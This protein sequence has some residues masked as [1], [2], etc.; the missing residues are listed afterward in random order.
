M[1]TKDGVRLIEY[2]ARFGDPEAMNVLAVLNSDFAAIC[3]AMISGKLTRDLVQFA[4][5]ATVCKYAVPEGY[6]DH[7]V[8][9]TEINI[10]DV[11]NT[12]STL[13]CRSGYARE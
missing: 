12:R 10:S 13:S 9:N 6:P 1:A 2:N 4:N 11:K 5:L 8:K 7:P 3:Q